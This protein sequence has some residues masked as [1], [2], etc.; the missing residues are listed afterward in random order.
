MLHTPIFN[1]FLHGADVNCTMMVLGDQP[2]RGTWHWT[3]KA[4]LSV[5]VVQCV[6][7][8]CDGGWASAGQLGNPQPRAS[9]ISSVCA[10]GHKCML[11]VE[12]NSIMSRHVGIGCYKILH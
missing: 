2:S 9:A 10:D 1:G 5:L 4:V 11:E 6:L 7:V 3:M 12:F 8:S